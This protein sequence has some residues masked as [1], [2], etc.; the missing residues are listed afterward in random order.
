M[1]ATSP[2]PPGPID[3]HCHLLIDV[4]DG[5]QTPAQ[6]LGGIARMRRRGFVGSVCTPHLF[7]VLFADN[8][9]A[10]VARWVD[11]L[12]RRVDQAGI[13]YALW[14]G[15]ELRIADDNIEWMR[16]HGV[17]TLGDGRSVLFDHWN[18]HWP[19]AGDALCAWLLGEGYTPILAHPER[20]PLDDAALGRLLDRLQ[21]MGVLLQGNF[22]SFSGGEGEAAA[23]WARRLLREG[24]Y[25]LLA[26]DLHDPDH[27][28]GRF[29]GLAIAQV[30][31]GPEVVAELI[32]TNPRQV[33]GLIE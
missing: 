25:F 2:I 21:A 15:G 16:T 9:P 4:D 26:S 29:E 14:P 19:S 23:V 8:T 28:E 11:D 5:C 33:L 3:V 27:T 6:A 7:P 32:E 22:N 13:D 10:N 1:D 18:G 12:R 31:A 30:E 24:R 20:M 17:P